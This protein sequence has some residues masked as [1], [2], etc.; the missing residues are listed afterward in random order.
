M[1]GSKMVLSG[2]KLILFAIVHN[3]FEITIETE[4]WW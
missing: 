3:P 1:L 2:K 4:I